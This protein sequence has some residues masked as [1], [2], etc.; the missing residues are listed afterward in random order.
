MAQA[1]QITVGAESKPGVLAK[2][3]DTLGKARVNIVAVC[4][5]DATGAARSGW[6]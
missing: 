6:S 1:T 4:A 5:A 2:A 3:C